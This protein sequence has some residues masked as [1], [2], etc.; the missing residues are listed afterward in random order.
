MKALVTGATGL[1][2]RALVARLDAPNALGRDVAR[3]RATLGPAVT[4]F[5]W[6]PAS[7]PAPSQAF[8]G[9]EV[10]F[11][12]AGESVAGGRWTAEQKRR[13]KDSRV[14]GTR[15]LVA[16]LRARPSPPRLLVSVSAVG[17]YGDRGDT[18]LDEHAGKG[19]GFLAD[20]CEEWEAEARQAEQSN[21]RVVILRLGLVF[22]AKGGALERML[23]PFRLG[24]GGKLGS[25]RQWMPWV[26]IDDAVGLLLH[27]AE[28]HTSTPIVNAVSPR[29]VTNAEFTRSLGRALGRPTFMPVPS[30][31]LRVALGEMSTALLDSQRVVPRA[32]LGS[33]YSFAYPELDR[34]LAA[35]LKPDKKA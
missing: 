14:L 30:P 22:A 6:Q 34:A 29:A 26:H 23:T 5:S 7:E 13:I 24:V 33:G 28:G 1:V 25:G 27:A 20:V 19:E 11:H 12:L 4:V 17:Y 31:L 9:V 3:A 10:V 21:T 2:G 15:N 32:A 8:D 16:T 35:C 18:E